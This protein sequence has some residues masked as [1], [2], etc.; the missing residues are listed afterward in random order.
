MSTVLL[1]RNIFDV[2][3]KK[4]GNEEQICRGNV[5]GFPNWKV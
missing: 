1:N 2:I 3:G 5:D 4:K